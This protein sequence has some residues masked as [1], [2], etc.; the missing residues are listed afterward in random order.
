MALELTKVHHYVKE[1]GG[2][3][4]RLHSTTPYVRLYRL[5]ETPVFLQGGEFYY[6]GGEVVERPLAPWLLAELQNTHPRTLREC[7][8]K[9]IP[10]GN[11]PDL[12]DG[13]DRKE[14]VVRRPT[15][16]RNP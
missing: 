13:E 9:E 7:G 4:V 16:R 10:K 3:S 11:G 1:P 5:G 12:T 2:N 6:E 8:L 14:T 15:V